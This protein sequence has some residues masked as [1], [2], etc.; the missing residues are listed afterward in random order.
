MRGQASE[1]LGDGAKR[2]VGRLAAWGQGHGGQAGMEP[3]LGPG[4]EGGAAFQTA[5]AGLVVALNA[6]LAREI[7]PDEIIQSNGGCAV[8]R[9][10]GMP[11][12]WALRGGGHGPR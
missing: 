9:G 12:Q 7:E 11:A 10:K 2:D 6:V 4:G 5:L 3:F 8:L 1:I